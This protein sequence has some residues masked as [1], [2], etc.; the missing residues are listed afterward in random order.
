MPL[1]CSELSMAEPHVYYLLDRPKEQLRLISFK[2][3]PGSNAYLEM[4]TFEL[5]ESS[6]YEALSYTY[7][8]QQRWFK[9]PHSPEW[10][11]IRCG[12]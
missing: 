6:T 7:L 1:P 8:G 4:R 11:G 12:E 10:Q 5:S 2:L 3:M 9:A